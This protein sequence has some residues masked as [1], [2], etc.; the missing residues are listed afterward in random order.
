MGLFRLGWFQASFALPKLKVKDMGT[1]TRRAQAFIFF[2]DKKRR[3]VS[4][5][6][7]FCFFALRHLCT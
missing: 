4:L 6:L 7:F 3:R 1:C 5:D 2:G